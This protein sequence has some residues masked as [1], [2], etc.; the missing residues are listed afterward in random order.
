MAGAETRL[1]ILRGCTLF[2]GYGG[3]PAHE[4]AVLSSRTCSFCRRS[5]LRSLS[6]QDEEMDVDATGDPGFETQGH[7]TF[8]NGSGPA[9]FLFLQGIKSVDFDM[10]LV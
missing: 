3:P 7:G 8:C 2:L 4:I 9:Y 5:S 6:R 10:H 1:T